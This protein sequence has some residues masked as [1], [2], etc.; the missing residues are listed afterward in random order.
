[1]V[2]KERLHEIIELHLQFSNASR[3]EYVHEAISLNDIPADM[4]EDEIIKRVAS[5]SEHFT[6]A[7]DICSDSVLRFANP[8]T[9]EK[10]EYC[11]SVGCRMV[12][13]QS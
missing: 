11:G 10:V 5:I 12:R 2:T 4:L 7:K 6:P 9:G 8:F 3:R 13:S 1:M